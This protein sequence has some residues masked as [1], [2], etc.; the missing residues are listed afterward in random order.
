MDKKELKK[1]L[2]E[3]NNI[4][5]IIDNLEKEL[6]ES[7]IKAINYTK[8]KIDN[9][10]KYTLDNELFNR[11]DIK[12]QIKKLELKKK[13]I[14]NALVV[15]DDRELFVIKNLYFKNWTKE[16]IQV[17][18]NISYSSLKLIENNSLDKLLEVLKG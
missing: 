5:S 11:E 1:I 2:L 15:L 12:K 18:L 6:K 3:F 4:D 9:S 13:M 16:A 10:C 7:N 14:E 8:T 17:A